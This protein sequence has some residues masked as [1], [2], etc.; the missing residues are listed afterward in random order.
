MAGVLCL[1]ESLDVSFVH[2]VCIANLKHAMVH[3]VQHLLQIAEE[4]LFAL[5]WV[6]SRGQQPSA[7]EIPGERRPAV[8]GGTADIV[9]C[10]S[11]LHR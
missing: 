5:F 6:P 11:N 8:W 10:T 7:Q 9:S 1:E 2:K 3:L 4:V